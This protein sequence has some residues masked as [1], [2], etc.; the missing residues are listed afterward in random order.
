[1]SNGPIEIELTPPANDEIPFTPPP[2]HRSLRAETP[3]LEITTKKA[4]CQMRA[5][6]LVSE[7]NPPI[8]VVGPGGEHHIGFDAS[9]CTPPDFLTGHVDSR[10]NIVGNEDTITARRNAR[11]A[12]Q[13]AQ[14]SEGNVPTARRL[15]SGHLL[16]T[17]PQYATINWTLKQFLSGAWCERT[18]LICFLIVAILHIV[19]VSIHLSNGSGPSSI[20]SDIDLEI[21]SHNMGTLPMLVSFESYNIA[22]I[23]LTMFGIFAMLIQYIIVLNVYITAASIHLVVTMSYA[24]GFCFG[25]RLI[26]PFVLIGLALNN[27][28]KLSFCMIALDQIY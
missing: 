24:T 8:I 25:L 4:L 2:P 22:T 19:I 9:I 7:L 16:Y 26:L 21:S 11:S 20:P 5:G 27:R 28:D 6:T 1:M 3:P 17:K 18:D 23:W 12:L 14:V 15:R 13:T 10:D